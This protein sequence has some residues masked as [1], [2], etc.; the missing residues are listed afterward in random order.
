MNLKVMIGYPTGEFGRRVDFYDFMNQ[1]EVPCDQLR[2]TPHG[3][4]PAKARNIIFEQALLNNCSHVFLVD[5][6]MELKPDTLI[7]L[8]A[9]DKDIVSGLYLQRAWP[10]RPIAFSAFDEKGQTLFVH[11]DENTK[12]L[13]PVVATG[14]G[15]CLIK[16]EVLKKVSRPW[17][18]LG[19]INPEEWCDDINF[20]WKLHKEAP[21]VE[22]YLDTEVRPGHMGSMILRAYQDDKGAWYTG[23]DASGNYQINVP[24]VGIFRASVS[25][26]DQAKQIEG[27]MSDEEL[28][29]LADT[30]KDKSL[31]VEFGS[32]CGRSTRALADNAPE[33]CRIIAVDP[34]TG[35]YFGDNNAQVNILG[36]SR[37]VDFQAN[38]RDYIL[39]GKVLPVKKL[40]H[41]FELVSEKAD[42]VFIDGDHR[43]ASVVK[44]IENGLSM[45]KP[46]GILSGH[47]YNYE[48]WP[49]VTRAVDEKFGKENV[50]SVGTIWWVQV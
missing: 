8:L 9:H 25:D 28:Q 33:T 45:L 37:F 15:C 23:Y 21:E 31:I 47:D 36:G 16:T 40:S 1:L 17:V 34:W 2:I 6:D 18:Q 38:L 13:I 26:I 10:H 42:F 11:L 5:D 12:G 46:G 4:S 48:G 39:N 7:K 27:W 41:D 14:F 44:D 3:Q 30:S 50:N 24:R 43:Y 29:W 22:I 35:E 49:E 20:F 32:H 19:N